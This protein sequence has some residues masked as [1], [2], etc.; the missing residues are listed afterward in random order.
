M[1]QALKLTQQLV[2]NLLHVIELNI[3]IKVQSD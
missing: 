2:I 1:V 3:L